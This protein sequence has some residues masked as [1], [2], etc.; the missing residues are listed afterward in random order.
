MLQVAPRNT[1]VTAQDV[2]LV[3]SAPGNGLGF[4]PAHSSAGTPVSSHAE[5]LLASGP[6]AVALDMESPDVRAER[7]RVS[8]M[9]SFENKC[10]VMQDLRK[11]YPPQVIWPTCCR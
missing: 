2:E 11:V 5:S 6:S 1:V 10:I 4:K 9:T 8:A 3:P 7:E